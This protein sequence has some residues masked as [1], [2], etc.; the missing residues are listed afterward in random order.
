MDTD[1]EFYTAPVVPRETQQWPDAYEED[2]VAAPWCPAPTST[3]TAPAYPY[4][5]DA[6]E[7]VVFPRYV[8]FPKV[9][10]ELR[11][12]LDNPEILANRQR[13]E[14]EARRDHD[15]LLLQPRPIQELHVRMRKF[16]FIEICKFSV[17]LFREAIMADDW[18]K[19]R[20]AQHNMDFCFERGIQLIE[21]RE[22]QIMTM[23]EGP[24]K[25]EM[26]RACEMDGR[27]FEYVFSD[28]LRYMAGTL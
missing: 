25:E 20:V 14:Y 23:R 3:P 6:T 5:Q 4:D 12:T 7:P 19:A 22:T 10:G 11:L 8:P 27:A 18:P 16:G 21:H 2:G 13:L 9:L 15:W 24:A 1:D 26:K 17:H 28:K